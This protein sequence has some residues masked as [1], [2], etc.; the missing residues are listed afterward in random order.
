MRDQ[1]NDSLGHT[2]D[3]RSPVIGSPPRKV[4]LDRQFTGKNP[5]RPS[6]ARAGR[7]FTGKLSARGYFSGGRFFNGE[8][9]YGAGDILLRGRRIK[10]AIISLRADFSWEIH[11]NMTPASVE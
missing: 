4:F 10:S 5:L 9:F 7:I 11:F 6:V 2:T 1:T 8:I 3:C